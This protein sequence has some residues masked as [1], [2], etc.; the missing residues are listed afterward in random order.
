MTEQPLTAVGSETTAPEPAVTKHWAAVQGL[1]VVSGIAAGV[2]SVLGLVGTA[3]P[4]PF[5]TVRG[6]AVELFGAGSYQ[7]DSLF[8]GAGNRGTDVVTLVIGLPLLILGVRGARRGLLRWQ[9]VLTGALAYLLYVYATMSVGAAFNPLFLVYVT[10]FGASLWGFVLSIGSIDRSSL[11]DAARLMPRRAPGLLL[12]AS[13]VVTT[14]IW[15]GPVLAAQFAGTAPARL[16]GYTTPVTVAIDC[17]VL[18]PAAIAAGV[19]I[20][21]RRPA[22]YL[23]GIPLLILLALLA[24]VIAAQTISQLSAGVILTPGEIVGPVSGFVA[25]AVAAVIALR[26]MLRQ[27]S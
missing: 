8:S 16:D 22:G 6:D 24:P 9:L 4:V 17:A 14:L 20:W 19:L 11:A 5:S 21:R 1:A 7:F 3:D 13:G 12:I 18:A 15:V 27:I 26:S 25:L 23:I 10:A 2:A